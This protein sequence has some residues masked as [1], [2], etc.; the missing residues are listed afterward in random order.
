MAF[1]LGICGIDVEP[2]SRKLTAPI[3]TLLSSIA[4]LEHIPENQMDAACAIGG[5]G[6]AFAYVSLSV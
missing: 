4:T 1:G 6:L 5:S 2:D 3:R